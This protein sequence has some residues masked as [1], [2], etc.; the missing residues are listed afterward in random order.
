MIR[1]ERFKKIGK[2]NLLATF[3]IYVEKVGWLNNFK[4]VDGSKGK[5]ISNPCLK[6][7]GKYEDITILTK[8][9]REWVLKEAINKLE[10]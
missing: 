7:G 3:T 2:G 4:L 6:H 9:C 8:E 10:N 5:F 1:I